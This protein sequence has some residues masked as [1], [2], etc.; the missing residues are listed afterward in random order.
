MPYCEAHP[1]AKAIA[2]GLCR[3]CYMRRRRAESAT[4][5]GRAP[6]GTQ[7]LMALRS[8]DLWE[9]RFWEKVDKSGD[10]HV[11]TGT[12]TKKGY[13]MF[14][15]AGRSLLAHRLAACLSGVDPLAQVI[16]HSCDN[17]VCVNPAHLSAGTYQLNSDDM[18]AKG[19]QVRPSGD[20]LRDRATHP[21]AKAVFTPLGT[22]PSASLAADAHGISPRKAQ[23]L[24]QQGYYA[25]ASGRETGWGYVD[26]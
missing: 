18:I 16:M 4:Y 9:D 3:N 6:T 10:C 22:F 23:K 14:F 17:P 5:A 12:R 20:H 13:G 8:P 15:V 2:H 7:Y 25:R 19:R 26:A 11:W 1:N 24:V 21:K